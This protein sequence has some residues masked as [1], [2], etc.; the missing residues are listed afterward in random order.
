[1]SEVGVVGAEHGYVLPLHAFYF[2]IKVVDAILH[3]LDLT[4][5][6]YDVFEQASLLAGQIFQELA[7]QHLA[8]VG[9]IL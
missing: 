4:V 2:I 5:Q 8:V 9:H 1:M 6:L 7:N 3:L